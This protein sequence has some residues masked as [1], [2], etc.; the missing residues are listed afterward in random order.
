MQ[1]ILNM[2]TIVKENFDYF[3]L[4]IFPVTFMMAALLYLLV[5]DK[6]EN[7][8]Y[9]YLSLLLVLIWISP[10]AANNIKTFFL[11]TGISYAQVLFAV[12]VV[13]LCAYTIVRLYDREKRKYRVMWIVAAVV[14]LQ[15]GLRFHYSLDAIQTKIDFVKVDSEIT[16]MN[17]ELALFPSRCLAPE[18]V[19][20]QLRENSIATSVLYGDYA[21]DTTDVKKLVKLADSYE[22]NVIILEKDELKQKDETYLGK[23]DFNKLIETEHYIVYVLL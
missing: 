6:K 1:G 13:G 12:P 5:R 9:R 7:P 17:E 15:V 20:S 19:A 18:Q 14:L 10:F 21:Y 3:N 11:G 8:N 2:M 16:R 23:N 22:C 4:Y